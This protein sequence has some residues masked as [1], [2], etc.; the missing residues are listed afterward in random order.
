MK[1]RTVV[2]AL[3]LAVSFSAFATA[4]N[5]APIPGIKNTP[6]F[7]NLLN[8]VDT[9]Q[10]KRDT[11]ASPDR[12]ASYRSKLSQ[13]RAGA[14]SAVKSLF[15]RRSARIASRDDKQERAQ[16][17]RIRRSQKQQV[18]TLRRAEENRLDDAADDYRSALNRIDARYA[19][20]LV[21]LANKRDALQRKLARTTNP[22][23]R[24]ALN[25]KLD[26]VQNK[27]NRVVRARQDD[28]DIATDRY[29]DRVSNIKDSC[30]R[31]IADVK[32]KSK[33]QVTKAHKAWRRTFRDDLNQIKQRRS[34]EFELVSNL[35]DRG[36]G[37]I[38]H[39]PPVAF[40]S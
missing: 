26:A 34:Q 25:R 29:K 3:I 20:K 32:A 31:Q 15:K 5:A 40:A 36:A 39:M 23:K 22:S 12:K 30:A 7:R 21:P 18:Q 28:T 38:D 33:R 10:A 27:I 9:L 37:Y 13:K 2:V 19:P 16:I 11:P 24:K 1:I 35:R 4:S 6:Q 8:Y 17:K 14:N